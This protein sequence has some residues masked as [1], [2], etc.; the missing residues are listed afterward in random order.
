MSRQNFYLLEKQREEIDKEFGEPLEWEEL[1]QRK[2]KE[3]RVVLRKDI[4][5]PIDEADWQNQHKW[6]VSK[7]EKF[8]EKFNAV[9]LPRLQE[10]IG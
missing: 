2:R 1:P 9:F 10:P 8:Y 4:T 5:N 6:I 7:I 3:S